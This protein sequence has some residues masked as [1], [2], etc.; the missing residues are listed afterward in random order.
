MQDKDYYN[1]NISNIFRA[2]TS[3]GDPAT[4]ESLTIEQ[5]EWLN[6]LELSVDK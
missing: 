5:I 2:L 4:M 1:E 6:D 3:R